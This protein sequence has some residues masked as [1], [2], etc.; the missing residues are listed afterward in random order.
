VTVG[1]TSPPYHLDARREEE[2]EKEFAEGG[3][4]QP[5]INPFPA[6]LVK[7]RKKRKKKKEILF[8][9]KKEDAA[10]PTVAITSSTKKKKGKKVAR[11]K[12]QEGERKGAP[13]TAALP[14]FLIL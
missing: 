12:K 10:V 11:K 14:G 6:S 7:E 13:S 9:K 3:T 8:K 5:L 2:K 4:G 1:C